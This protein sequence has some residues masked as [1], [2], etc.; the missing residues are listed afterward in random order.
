LPI[1]FSCPHCDHRLRTSDDKAGLSAKCPAC[2]EMI[3]VP[4]SQPSEA[5]SPASVPPAPPAI[6][7]DPLGAP[8]S[9]ARSGSE[10]RG[11]VDSGPPPV[12]HVDEILED[13]FDPP[14]PPRAKIAAADVICPACQASNDFGVRQCRFCGTS[15]EGVEPPLEPEWVPP[16]PE[17]GE[18]MSASW[19]IF[20]SEIGLLIGSFLLTF[21][22]W[23]MVLVI[24]ALPVLATTAVAATIDD[25]AIPFGIIAG[26]LLAVPLS[27]VGWAAVS[28]GYIRLNLRVARGEQA[29][30]GDLLYGIREGR[31]ASLGMVVVGFAYQFIGAALC[32]IG[33]VFAWPLVYV[34]TE[35]SDVGGSFN[36]SWKMFSDDAAAVVLPGLIVFGL[37]TACA[38]L[39]MCAYVGLILL[40][41]VV[42]YCMVLRAV[43]YLRLIKQ[44]TAIDHRL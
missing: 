29:G 31:S 27:I 30:I 18:I 35:E 7:D 6:P 22:L 20:Q 11:A 32:G 16:R 4:Y 19:K 3:W 1:E 44:R 25:D 33:K 9:P 2:G 26:C 14:P 21:F 5:E 10:A 23:L 40:V 42:P 37:E 28:V 39:N 8:D 12:V 43:A 15:L 38:L 13:T 24:C 36:R 41:F 34:Q 17:I